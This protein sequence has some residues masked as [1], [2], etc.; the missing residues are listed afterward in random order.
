MKPEFR[1]E[2]KIENTQVKTKQKYLFIIH[3]KFA[4]RKL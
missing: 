2:R 3:Q 4:T 1:S